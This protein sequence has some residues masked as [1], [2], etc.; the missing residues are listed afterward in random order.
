[1]RERILTVDSDFEQIQAF[2]R[3]AEKYKSDFQNSELSFFQNQPMKKTFQWVVSK[4]QRE[5][6]EQILRPKLYYALSQSGQASDCD[7]GFIFWAALLRSVNIPADEIF[8]C[9]AKDKASDDFYMHIFAGVQNPKT[10]KPI[11]LDNL[12]GCKFN[13]LDYPPNRFRFSPMSN[14]I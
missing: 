11:W 8:V 3:M 9:E 10:G 14:Y 12:P 2:C 7:D 6:G 1:M 4:Y 13:V 5:E